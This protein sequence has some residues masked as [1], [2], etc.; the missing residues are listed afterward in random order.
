MP[1]TRRRFV[2]DSALYAA[3]LG[4][5]G[6]GLSGCG[7]GAE[8]EGTSETAVPVA[9]LKPGMVLARDLMTREGVMLLAADYRL[10]ANLIRQIRDYATADGGAVIVFIR[11][12]R[13]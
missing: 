2:Y 6:T 5:L 9:N 3:A 1:T 12:D 7:G 11:N 4:V 10:D 8:P 13:R